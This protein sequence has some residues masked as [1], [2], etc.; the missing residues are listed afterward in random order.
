MKKVLIAAAMVALM[1]SSSFAAISLDLIGLSGVGDDV[2]QVSAAALS[3]TVTK[4]LS[5]AI[6]A[7][8]SSFSK[9]SDTGDDL[10]SMSVYANGYYTILRK[11]DVSQ[12]IGLEI[13]LYTDSVRDGDKPTSYTDLNGNYRV[14]VK[15]TPELSMLFDVE[16]LAVRNWQ[17]S[18]YD[19]TP[20]EQ[21]SVTILNG[22]K[23]GFSVPVM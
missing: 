13:A 7:G 8:T 20:G 23:I 1:A 4:D 14:A 22:A 10:S 21:A 15:V 9:P 3:F 16:V 12:A 11:G 2:Y 19:V 5:L 18:H 6:G 17:T